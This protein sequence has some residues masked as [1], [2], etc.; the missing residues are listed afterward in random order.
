MEHSE[1]MTIPYYIKKTEELVKR[2]MDIMEVL[3]NL[4]KRV[5][6]WPDRLFEEYNH[7]I[8]FISRLRVEQ[9]L[10]KEEDEC[11]DIPSS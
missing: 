2:N 4:E 9:P 8:K 6:L 5:Q 3:S 7:N 10:T 1:A 11:T